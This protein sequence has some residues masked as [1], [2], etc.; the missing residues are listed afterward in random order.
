MAFVKRTVYITLEQDKFLNE[1]A[2]KIGLKQ[3]KVVE[4]SQIVR[5]IVRL[6]QQ[7]VQPK[8]KKNAK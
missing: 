7:D 4:I 6:Y 8:G 1:V 5:S 3:G 2:V